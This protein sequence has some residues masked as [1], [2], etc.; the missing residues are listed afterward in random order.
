M[1]Q[2]KNI[3]KKYMTGNF[4]QIALDDVSLSFPDNEFAAI[5]GPS[6]SGKTTL[7]NIIGGLDHYDKGELY[8]DGV[9]T[10]KYKDRDWDTY[11]NNRIGFVFQSYNLIPHQ[12]VLSNVELALTLSGVSSSERTT[13]AKKALAEV[14]LEKHIHKKPNQLSGGQMQ[15]VALA[16]A[17]VNDPEI[18]LADEPTG[19]L[20]TKTSVQVMDMLTRI[21]KDRLVIMVTHNPELADQYANRI[22]NLKDGNIISDTNP[23]KISDNEY[24]KTE[25][26]K[27]SSMSFLTALSLS[28]SNLMTK[29]G[30]TFTVSLAGSFGIIG[31]A[32]ILALST[33]VK[34]YISKTEEETLSQYPL[35]IQSESIDLSDMLGIMKDDDDSPNGINEKKVVNTMLSNE[36]Q[37]DLKSLKEYIENNRDK[38]DP[39]S[40]LIDYSYDITPQIYLA[41]T[42]NKISQVNPDSIL[43]SVGIGGSTM[44]SQMSNMITNGNSPMNG[45]FSQMPT[46]NDMFKKQ[47]KIMAGSWPKNYDEAIL[48]LGPG[49]GVTDL[50]LYQLGL[51]NRDELQKML[52]NFID[53]NNEKVETEEISNISYSDIM[54]VKLKVVNASDKYEYDSKQKVWIDKSGNYNF[55]KVKI[56]N[57]IDL[58]IV[59]IVSPKED[60]GILSPGVNYTGSLVEHLMSEASESQIVKDQLADKTKNV[61]TGKL[62]SEDNEKSAFDF[63]KIISVDKNMIT[64]AFSMPS[65]S[66]MANINIDISDI[67][68]P[69]IDMSELNNLGELININ[70]EKLITVMYSVMGSFIDEEVEKGITDPTL[71][72]KDFNTYLA[73]AD[74]QKTI[75]DELSGLIDASS[76]QKQITTTIQTAMEKSMK[77]AMSE[78]SKKIKTQ[79]ETATKQIQSQ[80]S[81]QMA[82]V[83][84][85]KAFKMN[86]DEDELKDMIL[87]MMT[88]IEKNAEKNLTTFGYAKQDTPDAI[89]IYP[90]SFES[91]DNIIEFID[92]YNANANEEQKI[93]YSDLVGTL[94]SSITTII[95][96]ISYVLIAFVLVSLIVSSIMIGVITY[97]SVL[98]RKK[99]IGILRSIGASKGNIKS[100]FNAETLIIGFISGTIG[101]TI[102]ALV[103]FIANKIVYTKWDIANITILAPTTMLAL[104]AISMFLTFVSGLMPASSAARKDPVEALRSE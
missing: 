29:L 96:M 18:L 23:C 65:D 52:D 38:I 20:D 17:L 46:D 41:D 26:T 37:N 2:L 58:K 39:Y 50:A 40:S 45:S 63:S 3:S 36:S 103:C 84:L 16:R 12:T 86:M 89:K 62:F 83:D 75:Y 101:V 72:K 85:S 27:K 102:T 90:L 14:G 33:G 80:M 48:V 61:L 78:I 13:R 24:V 6:G 81:K 92:N 10:S 95:D 44:Q 74:V 82:N 100:V 30:R 88:N 19:A 35:T 77:S 94:M 42:D 11:R 54:N 64:K 53:S 91:K 98:E 15:R 25:P 68:M 104:I 56:A 93:E 57:G 32:V 49:G 4:T 60:T 5:L 7:L 28:F 22:I 1:L 55:M 71:L 43:Q 79:M 34:N 21:A 66:S 99:E 67:S 97:I 8:I 76:I 73:Q 59:G 87:S 31:I 69:E 9:P 51:R 70:P 47:Y